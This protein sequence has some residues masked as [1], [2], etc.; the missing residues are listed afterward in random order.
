MK[1]KQILFLLLCLVLLCGLYV[2]RGWLEQRRAEQ[3][4]EAGQ[5]F[6]FDGTSVKELAFHY[7]DEGGGL[8]RGERLSE[9]RWK[10]TEPNESIAPFHLMWNRVCAHL[11]GLMNERS[12]PMDLPDLAQYGLE[13]PRLMLEAGIDS[14]E[15]IRL[16]LGDLDILEQHHYARLNEGNVFLITADSFFELN[17]S[18]LDLRHRYLVSSR[19]ESLREMEFARIWTGTRAAEGEEASEEEEETEAKSTPEIGEESVL[20]RVKRESDEAPWELTSPVEAPANYEKVEALSQALQF[21][22]CADFIDTPEMLADYG[23]DPPRAR[24]SMKDQ[25]DR[26]WRVLWLG[27]VDTTP[28]KEG[29]FVRVEGQDTVLVTDTELLEFLPKGPLEWRDLRL[30]TRRISDIRKLDHKAPDGN[31]TLAKNEAGRWLLQEPEMDDVNDLAVNGYL[32]FIKVVAGESA[33]ES[34]QAE[35]LLAEAERTITLELDDGN[36]STLALVPHPEKEGV[37]WA[38]QDTGGIVLLEGVAVNTLL[39][40]AE[41]FRSK[42]ILRLQKEEVNALSFTLDNQEYRF[43][44]EEGLWKSESPASEGASALNQSDFDMLLD[45]LSP[46]KIKSLVTLEVPEDLEAY[47]LDTPVFQALI[48]VAGE[49]ITLAIGGISPD[50]LSERFVVSTSRQGL[51]RISQEV[52]DQLRE[53]VRGLPAVS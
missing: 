26:D 53:A 43:V 4:L 22:V 32:Q 36:H 47:G 39:S 33:V 44:Q 12:L 49:K 23:L 50:N 41:I 9:D 38:R 27:D 46:M 15:K 48:T 35:R 37:W 18:L 29:L 10:I 28:G 34:A 24:L 51:F 2:F 17:R 19:E 25:N 7:G 45:A 8:V 11:A 13:P 20:I 21:A 14:G 52:M 42:E 40:D 3:A 16:Q 31:F 6:S 30:I 1:L 5:V